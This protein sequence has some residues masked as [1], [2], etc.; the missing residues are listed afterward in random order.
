MDASALLKEVNSL[1]SCLESTQ[2]AVDVARQQIAELS[3]TVTSQQ[4]KLEQKD[5]QI[6]ELLK[7]LRGKQR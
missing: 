3:A 7:A 4:A 5:R 1:R 2:R 6:L